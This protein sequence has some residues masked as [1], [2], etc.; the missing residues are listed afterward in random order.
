[1]IVVRRMIVVLCVAALGAACGPEDAPAP[2]DTTPPQTTSP[3]P[4]SPSPE[5]GVTVGT[6]ESELGTILTDADGLTLY[7]FLNDSEGTSTCYDDCAQTWPALETE[8]DAQA[9]EGVD[10][11]LLGTSERQDGAL[12]V[13]YNGM[14]L[15]Y[16]ANDSEPGHTNGQGVGDVWYVVSPEGQPVRE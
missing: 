5:P 2:A 3:E 4:A 16:F 7:V 9:G 10:A 13:T 12:Q 11:S 15:Y 14:P 8:G 6:A 1:M